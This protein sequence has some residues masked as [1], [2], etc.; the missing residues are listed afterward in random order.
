[1]LSSNTYV[2]SYHALRRLIGIL[3]IALPFLCWGINAFVNHYDFLNNPAFVNTAYSSSYTAGAN[4]KSSISHFYYTAAGPLFTG[5]LITLAIFLFCYKGHARKE[6]KDKVAWLTDGLLSK[7]AAVCALLIVILPTGSDK[8]IIDN[9]HIYVSSDA[10]GLM[11]LIFAALFFVI[12]SLFCIINFRRN[13]N[14]GFIKNAE[15]NIYLFCGIGILVLLGILLID[16]V[17]GKDSGE[18]SFVF[19]MEAAM[20]FLFGLAWLVKGKSVVTEYVIDKL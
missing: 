20:L 4:L 11:H 1:M 7:V 2:I 3:G 18:G 15:G 12:M 19:W 5:V 6:S 8:P 10:A 13:G 14:N 9:I 17:S 16:M